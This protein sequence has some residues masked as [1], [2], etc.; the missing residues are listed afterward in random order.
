MN[1]ADIIDQVTL[2][3][4]K[5]PQRFGVGDDA[6]LV[7]NNRAVTQDTMVEGIHWDEKLTAQ[8]VGWKI[9]AVNASDIAAMGGLPEWATLSLSVPKD[10]SEEWIKDFSAGMRSALKRWQLLLVGG[11]T[12]RSSGPIV[13]SMHMCSLRQMNWAF[14]HTAEVKDDVWVTGSLGDAAVGF[15]EP[16][17]FPHN[18]ALQR[19]IPPVEF[20]HHIQ[21]IGSIQS[22]TDISD[23]LNVDLHRLCKKSNVG[24]LIDPNSLP[25]SSSLYGSKNALQYQTSFGE[26]YEM[27]FTAKPSYESLLRRQAAHFRISITKIGK[28]TED[29]S[30]RLRD[31]NWPKSMFKH[32]E[33]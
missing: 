6:A 24:A 3:C 9:V 5:A 1:E 33:D 17:K 14:Q 16:E 12:T 10:I 15:F 18:D 7:G 30:V 27:L 2:G 23:G 29:L 11:D 4:V 32:F 28:I 8:D 26:D 19:P 22:M 21:K 20:A 31:T 25:S 13:V